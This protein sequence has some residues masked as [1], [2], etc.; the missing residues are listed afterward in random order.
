MCF[1][2]GKTTNYQHNAAV[3]LSAVAGFLLVVFVVVVAQKIF[4]KKEDKKR[5]NPT[6][7]P[8]KL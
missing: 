2:A 1:V 6:P 8:L 5:S 7:M 3:G 4:R